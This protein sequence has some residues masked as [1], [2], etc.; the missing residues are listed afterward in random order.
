MPKKI[1]K[2]LILWQTFTLIGSVGFDGAV[3]LLDFLKVPI[4]IDIALAMLTNV[5]LKEISVLFFLIGLSFLFTLV[6]ILYKE[7]NLIG[8]IICNLVFFMQ[9]WAIIVKLP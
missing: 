8:Q 2:L 5:F 7:L 9:I 3:I 4:P 1:V 6:H